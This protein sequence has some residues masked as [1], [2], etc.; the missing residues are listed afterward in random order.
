MKDLLKRLTSRKFLLTVAAGLTFYAN[1]QYTELAA[2]IIAYLTAE[3]GAD[4]AQRYQAERTKQA[5]AVLE[6]TKIQYGDL[7]GTISPDR[8]NVVPGSQLPE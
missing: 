5:N 7:P 4:I 1:G 2:T 8:G 6:D 3:G